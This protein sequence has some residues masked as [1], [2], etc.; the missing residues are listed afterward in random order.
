[1][2]RVKAQKPAGAGNPTFTIGKQYYVRGRY[3]VLRALS[4]DGKTAFVDTM[5]DEPK[6]VSGKY[7]ALETSVLPVEAKEVHRRG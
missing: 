7:E 2:S 6:R 4:R 5:P 3:V 1:M